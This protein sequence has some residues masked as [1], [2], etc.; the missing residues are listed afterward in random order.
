MM[1]GCKRDSNARRSAG[2]QAGG[3]AEKYGPRFSKLEKLGVP[4][5]A[6]LLYKTAIEST[7]SVLEKEATLPNNRTSMA[8]AYLFVFAAYLLVLVR[9]EYR[10]DIIANRLG[11]S[12]SYHL[13]RKS[14]Q[15]DIIS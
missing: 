1:G 15:K 13:T 9:I 2:R 5:R 8:L 11:G 12:Y 6:I 14:H 3:H 4:L 10:M 7:V